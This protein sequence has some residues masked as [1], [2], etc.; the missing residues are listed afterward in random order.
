[1]GKPTFKSSKQ[2]KPSKPVAKAKPP[3]KRPDTGPWQ[4]WYPILIDECPAD[5]LEHAQAIRDTATA[6][7]VVDVLTVELVEY[8]TKGYHRFAQI[9]AERRRAQVA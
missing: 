8:I 6:L 5:Q 7:G 9:D 2:I 4:N 3:K 1:M